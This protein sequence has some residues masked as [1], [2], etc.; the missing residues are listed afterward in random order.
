MGAVAAIAAIGLLLA[1]LSTK[2]A[3]PFISAADGLN[4]LMVHSV[5]PFV[6]FGAASIRLPEYTGWAANVYVLYYVPLTILVVSLW[7]WTPLGLPGSDNHT[8]RLF[9]N[10]LCSLRL[11]ERQDRKPNRKERKGTA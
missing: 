7:R 3:G 1:Q 11:K 9:A 6:S 5:D 8:S 4:S 10:A 2:L